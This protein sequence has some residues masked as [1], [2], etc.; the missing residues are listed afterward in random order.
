LWALVAFVLLGILGWLGIMVA[1][2]CTHSLDVQFVSAKYDGGVEFIGDRSDEHSQTKYFSVRVKNKN[3]QPVT[4]DCPLVL[5]WQEHALPLHRVTPEVLRAMDVAVKGM[6]YRG[7]EWKIGFLG[8]GDQNQDFGIEFHMRDDRI[9][10]F[11]ARHNSSAPCPFQLSK[12]D[13][14]PTT[15]PLSDE[16]LEKAF[17]QPIEITWFWGH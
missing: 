5:H 17:A 13:Q 10:E 12:G 15:F 9:V 14:P 8:G 11:Y 7:P 16:Q 6:D 4:S 1:I 3:D 2:D